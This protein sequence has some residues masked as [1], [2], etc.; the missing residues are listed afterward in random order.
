MGENSKGGWT[1]FSISKYV[2]GTCLAV[3][4]MFGWLPIE[5]SKGSLSM[6]IRHVEAVPWYSCASLDKKK[7]PR[8]R[9]FLL[10]NLKNFS[11]FC[12]TSGY[13]FSLPFEF[14]LNTVKIFSVFLLYFSRP[15]W[16]SQKVTFEKNWSWTPRNS[17][18]ACVNPRQIFFFFFFCGGHL[19]HISST[20]SES[21][22][23]DF[24]FF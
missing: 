13:Y 17:K 15:P 20:I 18:L 4:R 8:L 2:R 3:A 14:L 21:H 12:F 5:T 1:D 9:K 16:P 7:E 23:A 19:R 10:S 24:F 22:L 6:P 11:P